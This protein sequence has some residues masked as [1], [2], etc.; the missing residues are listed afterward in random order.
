MAFELVAEPHVYRL[1]AHSLESPTVREQKTTD[2]PFY[3]VDFRAWL[4]A[5]E[6]NILSVGTV[7]EK[8]SKSIT[9]AETALSPQR[10]KVS[11][12]ITAVAG[13]ADDYN[14]LVPVTL[15]TDTAASV[16]TAEILLRVA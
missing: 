4:L 8:D 15:D 11:F 7:T 12:Q 3:N 6:H 2:T 14:L 5:N 13:G 1:T 9:I 10:D 16:V